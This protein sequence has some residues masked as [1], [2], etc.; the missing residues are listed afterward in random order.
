MKKPNFSIKGFREYVKIEYFPF[1]KDDDD[2][3]PNFFEH[4]DDNYIILEGTIFKIPNLTLSW[5]LIL[6]YSN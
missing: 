1:I 2:F 5:H 4:N 6:Q 3:D